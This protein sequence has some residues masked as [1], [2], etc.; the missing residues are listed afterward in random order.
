VSTGERE[1]RKHGIGNG[2]RWG[3]A[4]RRAERVGL[5]DYDYTQKRKKGSASNKLLEA[6]HAVKCSLPFF[7]DGYEI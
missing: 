4:M 2:E 1:Q 3:S 7:Y 6:I 5:A